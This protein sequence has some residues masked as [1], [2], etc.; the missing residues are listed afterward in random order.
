MALGSTQPLTEK[1]T[2]NISWGVKVAGA[3]GWQPYHLHV[4]IV[5]KYGKLSLLEPSGPVQACNGIVL[6]VQLNIV[7]FDG[8][9]IQLTC[10]NVSFLGTLANLRKANINFVTS[11]RPSVCMQQLLPLNGF[12]WNLIFQYF[13]KKPVENFQISLKSD[14]DNGYF[15]W[16]SIHSSIRSRCILL[17]MRNVSNKFEEKIKTH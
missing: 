7:V 10:R 17:R 13:K 8:V 5:L 15:T 11:V 16:R 9:L 12:S 3:Y 1:S 14:K 2:S 6:H 4:P